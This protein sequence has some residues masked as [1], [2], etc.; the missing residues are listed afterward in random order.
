MSIRGMVARHSD[1]EDTKD[2]IPTPPFA[3]RALYEVV[4]PELKEL[5]PRT[6][7]WD[8]AA[9]HGHM[10][11]VAKEYGHPVV[12]GSDVTPWEDDEVSVTHADFVSPDKASFRVGVI[13]TNP[14]YAE[15]E[16]FLR[17]G[18]DRAEVGLAMLVRVQA[19]ETQGRYNNIYSVVPPTQIAFFSDRIPFKTGAVVKKAPKM[20]FHVWLYWDMLAVRAGRAIAAQRP[21]LWIPPTIQRDLEKDSDY[22]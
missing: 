15:L 19:L 18:M 4:A 2:F 16:G 1:F 21:P 12:I 11:K 6:S 22:V 13:V 9:G 17:E 14:P 3:T 10:M 20:F 8:P 7:F 5:A